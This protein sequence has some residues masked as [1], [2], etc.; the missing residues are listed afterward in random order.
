MVSHLL[1]TKV[2]EFFQYLKATRRNFKILVIGDVGSGKT[3]LVNNLLGEDIALD[4]C[5]SSILSTFHGVVPCG[6]P[7]MVHETSGLENPDAEGDAEFKRKMQFLLSSGEVDIIIYCFKVYETRMRASLLHTLQGYHNMGLDWRKTVI[8]L[9]FADILPISKSVRLTASFNEAH[10]FNERV[11][12]ATLAIK[13]ALTNHV[14]L[15]SHVVEAIHIGPT[16]DNVE[17]HLPNQEQWYEPFWSMC[18]KVTI[19]STPT[20]VALQPSTQPKATPTDS[21]T[22]PPA[23]VSNPKS[24]CKLSNWCM[25][26]GLYVHVCVV[27]DL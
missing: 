22:V 14:G 8:A 3:R 17:E 6:V 9:T 26:L 18:L 13:L 12:E 23:I 5:A 16:L 24:E 7:V 27:E 4:S 19:P 15:P 10:S 21:L 20:N 1:P 11:V 2:L 25:W